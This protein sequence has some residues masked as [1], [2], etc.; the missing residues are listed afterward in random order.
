MPLFLFFLILT[1]GHFFRRERK[2]ERETSYINERELIGCLAYVPRIKSTTWECA[3]TG[4]GTSE[5]LV[6][7][8]T[9]QQTEP[10]RPERV[11]LSKQ[12]FLQFCMLL[13]NVHGVFPCNISLCND[14]I[15]PIPVSLSMSNSN[16]QNLEPALEVLAINQMVPV[17]KE[18]T[19]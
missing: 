16:N 7:G 13:A 12:V 11:P 3:L 8:M 15:L 19:T 5:L 17:L 1:Q 14:W 9:L 2:G 10:H 4:D 18:F 6:C